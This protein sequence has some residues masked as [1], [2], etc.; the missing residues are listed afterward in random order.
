M[1]VPNHFA[2]HDTSTIAAFMRAH[3]FG[4]VLTVAKGEP[5]ISHVP[6][7]VMPGDTRVQWHLARANPQTAELLAQGRAT[8]VF[9]GPHAYVSPR[10]YESPSVPTWNF[11]AVHVSGAVQGLDAA[12]TAELVATLSH[13]YDGD[14][15]LRGFAGTPPYARMLEAIAGFE[16]SIE[17]CTAKFKLSQNRSEADRRAVARQLLASVR[18]EERETGEMMAGAFADRP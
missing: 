1:Y 8:L 10:L 6:L 15:S 4:L 16:L 2:E 7:H 11:A 17:R 18:S 13:E 3:P 9:H 12:A 5:F 14:A